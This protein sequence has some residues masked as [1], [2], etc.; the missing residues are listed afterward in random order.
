M[1]LVFLS[2]LHL[3]ANSQ[4]INKNF[5]GLLQA[6]KCDAFEG[7]FILGDLFDAWLGD[8]VA[9]DFALDI[10]DALKALAE[11]KPVFFQRGNRDFLLA[12]KFCQRSGLTLLPDVFVFE[13]G[14]KRLLLEHGDL[15]CWQDVAYQRMR[16]VLRSRF[17]YVL[18]EKVPLFLLR[19]VASFLRKQSGRKALLGAGERMDVSERAV[20]ERF[21]Q[22]E[23]DIMLHGHTHR[24]CVHDIGQG[25]RVV[26]G[27]WRPDGEI[28]ILDDKGFG[29]FLSAQ[30][31]MQMRN[32]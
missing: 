17:F 24:P 25:V 4:E 23:V 12:K 5:I 22:Y 11:F 10:A 2:D 7:I 21:A 26:L 31:F 20:I 32:C 27:D 9:A 13:Y 1:A 30:D 29:L 18:A 3:S 8:G 14:G 6:L 16:R 19:A 15:L 28:F